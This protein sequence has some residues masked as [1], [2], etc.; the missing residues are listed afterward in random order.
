MID[1]DEITRELKKHRVVDVERATG[2]HRNTISK[3]RLGK[4]PPQLETL[5]AILKF[6]DDQK[7]AKE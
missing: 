2:L 6:I 7:S 1:M 4:R 5:N 3:I